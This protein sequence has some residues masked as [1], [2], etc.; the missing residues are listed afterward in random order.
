MKDYNV[1]DI[2]L[3]TAFIKRGEN[4]IIF[5]DCM[6]NEWIYGNKQILEFINNDIFVK[7]YKYIH[8][9]EFDERKIYYFLNI[10]D[11]IDYLA[12]ATLIKKN[13]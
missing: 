11:D 2:F 7:Y 4:Q 1:N 10:N 9:K 3:I 13:S 8:Y 6:R 5:F 12:T